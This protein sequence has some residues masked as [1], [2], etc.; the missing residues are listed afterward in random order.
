MT[1]AVTLFEFL[2]T[3][4][5][6]TPD[7]VSWLSGLAALAPP[8]LVALAGSDAAFASPGGVIALG[9]THPFFLLLLGVWAVRVPSSALAGEIGRG[10]MD[11]LAGRPVTRSQL[12]ISTFLGFALGLALIMFAAWTGTAIGLSLRPLGVTGGRFVGV[13]AMAWL[14]FTSFGAVSVLISATAREAGHAIAWTS[15]IIATSFVLE[16]LGRV[17]KPVAG[18]RPLSPFAYYRP[19]QIVTGG[20]AASDVTP[21]AALMAVAIVAAIVV[22]RKRDL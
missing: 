3:R 7:E 1:A 17:W 15:G 21:L 19:H 20:I 22:F 9:Y 4:L 12:V 2:T 6:P 5:A 11:L 14:L 18:L 10:T 16:Y 8:Q 13:G